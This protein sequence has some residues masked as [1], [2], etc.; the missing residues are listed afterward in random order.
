MAR[1]SQSVE[2]V[3]Q[4]H[5]GDLRS[6]LLEAALKALSEPEPQPLSFR[7]LARRLGVTTAAPYHH[8]RDRTDLLVQLAIQGLGLLFLEV[9]AAAEPGDSL[10][11]KI[12]AFTL[13]YLR[14]ARTQPG[15]YRLIFSPEVR[16]AGESVPE[17]REASNKSF[18]LICRML[19]EDDPDLSKKAARER[20]VSLWALLHGLAVLS[21]AGTLTR[22]L[23]AADENRVAVDAAIRLLC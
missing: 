17:F 20:A 18:D 5:H 10:K 16:S 7:D 13:A 22:R 11:A 2:N 6:A 19:A 23:A 21:S 3:S 9:N 8:F 1:K 14:F 12:R 4:Y 15:Y